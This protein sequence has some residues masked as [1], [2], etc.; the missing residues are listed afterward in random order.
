MKTTLFP[1]P[2]TPWRS[3]QRHFLALLL[4]LCAQLGASTVHSATPGMVVAWGGNAY[5]NDFGQAR[6][7]AAAQSGVTAIAAGESHTVALKS[8]GSVLVWG[9]VATNVPVAA[10]SGVI[11]IAAGQH[12]VALKS[13]GSVVA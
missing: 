10:Q 8:D 7:P 4:I 2:P 11:A 5:D 1:T 9:G 13:D 6:V 12:T 3:P